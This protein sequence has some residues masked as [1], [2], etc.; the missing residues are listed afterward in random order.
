MVSIFTIT[1]ARYISF[2]IPMSTC[3]KILHDPEIYEDPFTFNPDRFLPGPNEKQPEMDPRKVAF[4]FG[5]RYV[6]QLLSH[7][8]HSTHLAHAT[9]QDMPRSAPRGGVGTH[10]RRHDAVCL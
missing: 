5:R 4:G 1:G 8:T 7:S 3:R 2:L 10:G 9:P 6:S